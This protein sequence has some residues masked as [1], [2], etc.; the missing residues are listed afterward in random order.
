[1]QDL[2]KELRFILQAAGVSAQELE[3]T[4]VNKQLLKDN[5]ISLDLVKERLEGDPFNM[6]DGQAVNR[7]LQLIKDEAGKPK[8]RYTPQEITTPIRNLV[9]PYKILSEA[10]EKAKIAQL[11]KVMASY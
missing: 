10:E 5:A 8:D 2:K 6:Y 1:M 4:L 3:G 7:V 11:G 9:G